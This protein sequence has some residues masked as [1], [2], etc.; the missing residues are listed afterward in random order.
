M[1]VHVETRRGRLERLAIMLEATGEFRVLRRL[2]P[3]V[4]TAPDCSP[5][6]R[7]VFLDVETTGLD[8]LQDTVI[9]LAMVPFDYDSNG[10]VVSIGEPFQG[11]RD[12]GGPISAEITALTGI[13]DSMVAGT[14]IDARRVEEIVS[15]V[16]IVIAHN[17]RFDRPFCEEL[18]PIFASKPWACS[19]REI[20]WK[21][22]GFSGA[23]L[24]DIAAG[25]GLFF[26]GH[27]AVE[28]C[29]AGVEIL[30]RDLPRT[31]GTAL[32][33]LL[34]SARQARWR[35]WAT[36][37]PFAFRE[38]LK[39]RGYRWSA[40]DNGRPR[41]WNIEV[42]EDERSSEVKFLR[43]EIFGSEDLELPAN[44]VTA[45]DRYSKRD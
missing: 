37:A 44:R 43:S 30:A 24:S 36:G 29:F 8:H 4:R 7:A 40:G 31:G 6:R 16:A 15:E 35:L 20:D 39:K 26:D 5:S 10:R 2:Y 34:E 12:P 32:A 23:K 18:W 9:E 11:F 1:T 28:D 17:A 21:S 25:H 27:R 22:E 38:L 33:R 45:F 14:S 41:A 3:P 42:T 19:W 13:T